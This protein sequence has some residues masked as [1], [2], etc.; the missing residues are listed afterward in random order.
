[1]EAYQLR[2]GSPFIGR[3]VLIEEVFDETS[4]AAIG[5]YDIMLRS[6]LTSDRPGVADPGMGV[7]AR[8]CV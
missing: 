1:M 3:G 4:L 5:N 8:E 6:R 7:C 2:E